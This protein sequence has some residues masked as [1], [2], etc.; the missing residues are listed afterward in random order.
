MEQATALSKSKPSLDSIIQR[1][2]TAKETLGENVMVLGHHYQR[3]EVFQFADM[4]GDSFNLTRAAAA[5]PKARY[6]VFCGVHFM[7]ES[8]DILTNDDQAVILP[9]LDAGCTMA[10][11]ATIEDV[12]EAWEIITE[13][14]PGRKILPIT[15]VNSSATVK[16]MVG[17]HGGSACTSSNAGAVIAWARK[18]ADQ[19]V[20]MPDQ[21]LGRNTCYK[22]GV[23]LDRMVLWDPGRETGG[24]TPEQLRRAE[25]ILWKGH[26]SVHQQFTT[27][28]IDYWRKEYPDIR[29]AVHPEC[30]FE[31]TQK[32]DYFSST[33]GIKKLIRDSPPG[34]RWAIGTEHHMVNRLAAAYPDRFIV[35]LTPFACQCSTMYRIDQ[36]K[37][38][39]VMEGLVE[40]KLINRIKVD[41]ETKRLARVALERMLELG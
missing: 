35:T 14:Q 31:V 1:I 29:I 37:L 8:A 24:L 26:C 18:R 22:M 17:R 4:A 33:E 2:G 3:D 27:R 38:L 30:S 34:S 20:F 41:D 36:A 11:M 9:D 40:G 23:P 16:A 15:Y 13:A 28:Q 25:V 5:N 32:A 19:L 12:E 39:R 21:H 6:I 10:D 7:A